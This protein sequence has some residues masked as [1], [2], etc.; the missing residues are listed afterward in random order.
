M[1]RVAKAPA[2]VRAGVRVAATK[3]ARGVVDA[4]LA[5]IGRR[6]NVRSIR[7]VYHYGS[8]VTAVA[9]RDRLSADEQR[10][11]ALRIAEGRGEA[12]VTPDALAAALDKAL[13]VPLARG[14]GSTMEEALD[15]LLSALT[16]AQ[17]GRS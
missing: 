5:Q 13:D 10:A 3:A 14:Q 4:L 17:G 15:S 12:S 6:P 7:T 1:A 16:Q 11:V 8:G 9:L 2:A